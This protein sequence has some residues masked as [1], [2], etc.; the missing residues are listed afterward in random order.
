MTVGR[1]GGGDCNFHIPIAFLKKRG[2]HELAY[3]FI[4]IF[5]IKMK[6]FIDFELF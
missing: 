2:N 1:T 5:F 4:N 6:S 3:I